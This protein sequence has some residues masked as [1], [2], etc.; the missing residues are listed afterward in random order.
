MSKVIKIDNNETINYKPIS[1]ISLVHSNSEIKQTIPLL[2]SKMIYDKQKGTVAGKEVLQT[3]HLIIDEAHNVLHSP[4]RLNSENFSEYRIK[5]FE[6]IVKE[7]R[8]FGFYLTFSS[9]RPADISPT[10]MSQIHNYLIHR[11]VH[12]KD[13]QMLINTMPTLDRFSLQNISSL[14]KGEAILTGVAIGMPTIIKIPKEELARPSSDDVNLIK[15]WTIPRRNKSPL[16]LSN[17]QKS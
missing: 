11:L 10:I 5:V 12:D 2:I 9:Q 14:G 8:K 1:I 13:I 16:Y 6:E 7:G 4:S 3:V 17:N 15:L